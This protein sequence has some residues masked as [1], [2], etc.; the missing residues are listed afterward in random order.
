MAFF[1]FLANLSAHHNNMF[2]CLLMLICACACVCVCVCVCVHVR[3]CLQIQF[4]TL[5]DYFN[6]V[7]T[8]AGMCK[9][10]LCAFVIVH[11]ILPPSPVILWIELGGKPKWLP[12]NFGYHGVMGT[13]PIVSTRPR[14]F[15]IFFTHS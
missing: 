5:H 6:G 15:C 7:L 10:G 3:V 14:P 8:S 11:T 2:E 12:L 4:G 9:W 13:S 1:T